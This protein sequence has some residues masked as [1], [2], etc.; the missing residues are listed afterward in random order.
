MIKLT[1]ISMICGCPSCSLKSRY[2]Q[3]CD[4]T[5]IFRV[6]PIFPAIVVRRT[7]IFTGK[8]GPRTDFSRTK[9]P[10]TGLIRKVCSWWF[11]KAV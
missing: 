4:R 11:N 5:K 3:D 9:I 2:S 1:Y 8:I 6:G 10:V 7:N